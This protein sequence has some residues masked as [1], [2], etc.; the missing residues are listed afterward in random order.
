MSQV[1]APEIDLFVSTTRA[2]LDRQMTIANVR[3]L[4]ARNIHFE[5]EW[6]RHGAEL[7]WTSLL[8]PEELGGG[9]VSGDGV[10]DL[11]SIAE[12]MGTVAAGGPL[13]PV[14]IVL[15][16]LADAGGHEEVVAGMIDG[17]AIASWA[18]YD[19]GQSF[20]PHSP[21]LVATPT[22]GGVRL[23]GIKDRVEA[24]TDSDYFLVTALEGTDARQFLV[25]AQTPGVSVTEQDCVDLVRG[26]ARVAFDNVD[27]P[28]TAEVGTADSTADLIARQCQIALVLQCAE[29][30]GVLRTVFDLTVEWAMERHSFGR[31]LASYQ[32]LKHRF[33]D[34]KMHL[35][36]CRAATASAVREVSARS[37][38]AA[39]AVSA[40]SAYIGEHAGTMIQ[41]C[42][43]LHGGIGVTWEHDLHVYLRRVALN[44]SLY[45]SP[46]YHHD[47][48]FSHF[49]ESEPKT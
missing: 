7:G 16:A 39:L 31:P 17:S 30:V 4:H 36:A 1:E 47:I 11:A 28:G 29:T 21:S 35:E 40:A 49:E 8:V 5:R 10:T 14:S 27:V 18:V 45:G 2:F 9:S 20:A 43:Q 24:G 42:V 38:G 26:F 3:D 13:N 19:A 46:D 22:E 37:S 48:V 33:A 23:H 44:R 12:L 6:W 25:P 34:L 41:E 15:A 32:A